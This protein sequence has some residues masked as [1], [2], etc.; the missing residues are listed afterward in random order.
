MYYSPFL[1]QYYFYMNISE[2]GDITTG[3]GGLLQVYIAY[4]LIWGI[5]GAMYHLVN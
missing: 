5:L 3:K 4:I 2:M 1:V